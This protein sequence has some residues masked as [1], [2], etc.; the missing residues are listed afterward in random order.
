MAQLDK[1][2][3]N[4]HSVGLENGAINILHVAVGGKAGLFG[5]L[6]LDVTDV[7]TGVITTYYYW[8]MTD[9]HLRYG[10][11]APTIATQDTAG[12]EVNH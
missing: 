6:A 1:L 12:A 4:V 8:P 2:G 7:T 10:T 9:G 11:T 3:T 5:C